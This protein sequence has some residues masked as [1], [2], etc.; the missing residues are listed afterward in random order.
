MCSNYSPVGLLITS[1]TAIAAAIIGRLFFTTRRGVLISV[2]FRNSEQLEAFSKYSPAGRSR[3][4]VEYFLHA[5][6]CTTQNQS[7]VTLKVLTKL[8]IGA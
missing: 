2:F 8:N 5:I 7:E 1:R 3:M 6:Q 4:H